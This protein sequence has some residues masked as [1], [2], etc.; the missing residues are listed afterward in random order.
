IQWTVNNAT[1]GVS[2]N[3][4]VEID[5]DTDK[6][7]F[8]EPFENYITQPTPRDSDGLSVGDKFDDISMP[9]SVEHI[10]PS[11]E[12]QG[13]IWTNK[14]GEG[15]GTD[16]GS[17]AIGESITIYFWVSEDMYI[18]I[19]DELPNGTTKVIGS[20]YVNGGRTYQITGV[21][22]VPSGG[23]MLYLVD[24]SGKVLD[25]CYIIVL[26]EVKFRGIAT[27]DE[28]YGQA[29]CYGSY[30]VKV[31][32]KEILYDPENTLEVGKEYEVCYGSDPKNIR[33]GDRLEVYGIS[34]I[35]AGPFQYY[36][37]VVAKGDGY[38]V[39]VIDQLSTLVVYKTAV[40]TTGDDYF[41]IIQDAVNAANDGD[42]IIVCP[43]TYNE[44]VYVDKSVEIRS[45]SQNP[46][47]TVVKGLNFDDYV[48]YVTA[49]D[50][51]I[52]GF[53]VAEAF[54]GIFLGSNNSRIENVNFS[55]ITQEG[56]LLYDSNNIIVNNTF[57]LTGMLV[58]DSYNNKVTNNTVNGK[59]LVYLENVNDY[60][61]ENA[62]QV[63]AVNSNNITVKNLDLSYTFVGIEFW[64]T[65]N[66]KIINNNI[67]NTIR[68]I[69]LDYSSNNTITN[70]NISNGLGIRL[71]RSNNNTIVNNIV[72]NNYLAMEFCY[73]SGNKI[74][75][76][77]FI[78]NTDQVYTYRST[79]IWNSS[80]KITYVYNGKQFTS[81]LGNYWSDYIGSD[82]DGDG[83]GD[84]PYAI[85]GDAD[86]YP[87]MEP[88]EYYC[89]PARTT[90]K[91][92]VTVSYEWHDGYIN[93]TIQLRNEGEESN[94]GGVHIRLENATFVSVDEGT[95]D[96][97]T[98]YDIIDPEAVDRD[99]ANHTMK[100]EEK[101]NVIELYVK[102]DSAQATARIK[103]GA[104][105]GLK[106]YY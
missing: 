99:P 73:S 88:W 7:S 91:P 106:I 13:D 3:M 45:Y 59:S 40:C 79:N 82:A 14:G 61:V 41:S 104:G 65:S 64:N 76:N 5:G 50:V 102:G 11:S 9:K 97:V 95:F 43:G 17:F 6:Y 98:A 24:S 8:M 80:E 15:A 37:R 30:Y 34:Y 18:E 28:A 57:H 48:F 85:D 10:L 93:L 63:I 4:Y 70:N 62:G 38:Y 12:V 66:S 36:G 22:G 103:P 90:P 25:S 105:D 35:K 58:F 74:H 39:K 31:R 84:I 53:T 54:F 78:D 81:Y 101:P 69:E 60:V 29:V 56:I 94:F 52:S 92:N 44:N 77:N 46:E 26:A 2:E 33:S 68:G 75:L 71:Y 47:D 49:D 51:K 83:I 19:W 27:T 42:T 87:L 100:I 1:D 16:G 72:S 55:N 32:V 89:Q 67:S 20:G 23:R 86:N 21:I 96:S